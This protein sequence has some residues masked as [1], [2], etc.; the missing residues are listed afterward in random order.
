MEIPVVTLSKNFYL[1]MV[2]NFKFWIPVWG[3]PIMAPPIFKSSFD[4]YSVKS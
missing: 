3:T 2:Q 1:E 4:T